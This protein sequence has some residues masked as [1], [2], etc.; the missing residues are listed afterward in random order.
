L[1]DGFERVSVSKENAGR[2]PRF[3][4]CRVFAMNT[5]QKDDLRMSF[6]LEQ[7]LLG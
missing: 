2:A 6:Y 5:R 3:S 4:F 1:R 7:L